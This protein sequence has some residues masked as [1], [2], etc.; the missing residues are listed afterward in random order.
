MTKPTWKPIQI[1]LGD[2]IPWGDNPKYS[3]KEDAKRLIET[4]QEFGQP[5]TF[6]VSPL[7]DNGKCNCYDG[8]QRDSAWR[9]AYG[10]DF[11]VWAMQSDRH[12]TEAERKRFVLRMHNAHGQWSSDILSGWGVDE[13]T[14]GWFDSATLKTWKA[15]VNWLDKFLQSEQAD[16][17]DAEVDES[18]ADELREKYGTELGQYWQIGEHRLFI[19]DSAFDV[20]G[21]AKLFDGRKAVLVHADPPY[22]MGKESEGIANDN[23]YREK[24]DAFQMAWWKN[25]RPHIEDNGSAYVW[26]VADDL[27]RLWYCG[28]LRDSER[29]TLRNEIVWDK[30]DGSNPTLRVNGKTFKGMRSYYNSERCIFFMLGEQGFNNNSD[31]YW[32]GWDNVRLYLKGE[33]D[34]VGLTPAKLQ[35]ICGVGMYGHWFTESQWTFIT[36]EHYRKLQDAFKRDYDAFKRD[37]DELKRDYDELKRDFYATRAHFD[38]SFENM[39]DVWHFPRVTGDDRMGHATPKPVEMMERIIKSSAPEGGL[40]YSPFLG[41]APEMRA[42]ERLGRVC[43]GA[44][45][46]AGYAALVLQAMSDAFP[47][48]PIRRL[49]ATG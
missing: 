39:T 1:R 8:H 7:M 40:V 22:G 36:E 46:D 42:C 31:N 3:T 10:D 23:L 34:K 27:W 37:Y 38:N 45:V 6:S 29:L 20:S 11:V 47:S 28:G 25:C 33:A 17:A 30:Q 9:T 2:L 12:L 18:R 21:I 15:D 48:L 43:Y 26:G 35:E 44:D 24:L 41:T 13:L 16:G 5:Q 49:D 32:N 19:G 4:E 14:Q